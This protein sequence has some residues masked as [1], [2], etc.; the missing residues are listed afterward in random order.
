MSFFRAGSPLHAMIGEL[1]IEAVWELERAL[2]NQ[3]RRQ[4]TAAERRVRELGFLAQLL[5]EQGHKPAPAAADDEDSLPP[6][7]RPAREAPTFTTVSRAIYDT[8]KPPE[9]PDSGTLVKHYGSW[10]KACRAADGLK[11]DG[12]TTGPGKP[13]RTRRGRIYTREEVI[14]AIRACAFSLLRRPSSSDYY[15]WYCARRQFLLRVGSPEPVITLP[16]IQARLG[17][18]PH[19]LAAAAITDAD[20]AAW[21]A[22]RL[23]RT[24]GL[25]GP[26]SPRGRLQADEQLLAELGLE[27]QR[28]Q[29]LAEGFGD[30]PLALACQI[31]Q[32]LGGSLDWL[33]E[34]TLEPG[35]PADPTSRFAGEAFA[36]LRRER[37]IP[38]AQVRQRLALPLG[39]Y[40]Q[41]LSGR[42]PI[43]LGQMQTL[44]SLVG[45]SIG[46]LVVTDRT[47][48]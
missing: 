20:L 30:L 10:R 39:P 21:R 31:A 45:V 9:A 22:D 18:W 35:Q 26:E 37:K 43:T 46:E 15:R 12:R 40:R 33:T 7:L 48:R 32:R 8:L 2:S 3:L 44:A 11:P 29:L 41:L 36:A 1:S 17:S 19:A 34:R 25:D 5:A 47:P 16:V 38:E 14:E 6:E 28:Q 4:P 23:P 27:A 42:W 13:W 24:G